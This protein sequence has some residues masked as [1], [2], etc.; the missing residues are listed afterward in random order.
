MWITRNTPAE[1]QKK[2]PRKILGVGLE[3]L[4][5]VVRHCS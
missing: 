4:A 1:G 5:M 3:A 2:R